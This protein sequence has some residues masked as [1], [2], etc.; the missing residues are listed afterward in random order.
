MIEI[1]GLSK[2]FGEKKVLESVSLKIE[3]GTVLS[4]IGGSGSGKSTFSKCLIRL[5]EPDAGRILVD[6]RDITHISDEF[7]LAAVRRNFGYLFQEGALFDSI[8]VADNVTFGLKYLTGIPEREYR[9]IATEKLALVGLENV[10]DL[11]PAELSGGMRKRVA[12]ARAIAAEPKYII[13]DEPTSGLD[14]I[15][16][17]IVNDL[18]LDMKRKIGVTSIVITHDMKSAGKI[19]DRIAMLYEGNFIMT[20]TPDEF[21]NS[22]NEFVRQ[23]VDGSS[24]GPIKMKLRD[25]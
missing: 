24:S 14:P 17:D 23:F 21:R 12:L 9:R 19:S 7:E 2:S 25:F 15:M 16:S 20:G 3:D 8:S 5:W 1:R 6:G 11:S 10:E 4:I 18:V 22:E 13:Y